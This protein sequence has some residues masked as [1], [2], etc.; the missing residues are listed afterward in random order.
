V[1]QEVFLDLA[2]AKH[3]INGKKLEIFPEEIN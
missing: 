3:F 2:G 1:C